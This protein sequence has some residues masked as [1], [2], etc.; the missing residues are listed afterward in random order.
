[1]QDT[2]NKWALAMQELQFELCLVTSRWSSSTLKSGA[3]IQH[4]PLV[5]KSTCTV[6]AL[7][8]PHLAVR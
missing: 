2:V 4:R 8:C 1:V 5:V 6:L 3:A 7:C